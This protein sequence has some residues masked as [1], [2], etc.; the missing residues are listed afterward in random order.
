MTNTL[1]ANMSKTTW[2]FAKVGAAKKKRKNY[3]IHLPVPLIGDK[4]EK[5]VRDRFIS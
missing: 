3:Q 4:L 5:W 1:D 2:K